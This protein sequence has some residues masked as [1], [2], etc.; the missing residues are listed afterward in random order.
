MKNIKTIFLKE[1]RY[2]FDSPIA[3]IVIVAFLLV[4]GFFFTVSLFLNNQATI[5]GFANNVPLF[6]LFFIPAITMRLFS[7]EVKSGTI[8]ILT[9]LPVKDFEI[10]LGKYL[11]A[12]ALMSVS[13]FL[14][15]IYPITV[16][17]LGDIDFGM[18][19]GTY[20]G[21]FLLGAGFVSVGI[22]AS[23]LTKNQIVAFIICFLMCFA[24]FVIGK[25]LAI[26]P[27]GLI[28]IFEFLGIDSHFDNIS[29]GV[30]DSR[31]LLYYFSLIGFFIFLTL[32]F[33]GSRRWR[34]E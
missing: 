21:L 22:F 12:L 28:G 29:K 8:E 34:I 1:L 7:E 6:F 31:D 13:L 19:V 26:L 33:M 3:D 11:S 24:F 25:L 4:N 9:T 27:P 18:V 10:V 16:G 5:I 20:I 30:I 17:F 32:Y 15:I 2:Y 14:T 23:S